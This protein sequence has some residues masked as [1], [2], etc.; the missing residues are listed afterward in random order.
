MNRD[1]GA[2]LMNPAIKHLQKMSR[3]PLGNYIVP[4]LVSSLLGGDGKGTV[5]LFERLEP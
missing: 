3:S 5:R 4:G 2:P 1:M